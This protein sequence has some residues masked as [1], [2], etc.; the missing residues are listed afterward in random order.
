[1]RSFNLGHSQVLKYPLTEESVSK[2]GATR[3]VSP[4]P[5]NSHGYECPADSVF[6][7]EIEEV[8]QVVAL[9][10]AG[11]WPSE[12]MKKHTGQAA[13]SQL[14]VKYL[15]LSE[16]DP[17]R[18]IRWLAVDH[19]FDFW[20]DVV[21]RYAID[22]KIPM[23]HGGPGINFINRVRTRALAHE[24]IYGALNRTFDVKYQYGKCRP[25]EMFDNTVEVIDTPNHP[26]MPG[27][28]ATFFAASVGAFR[29]LYRPTPEQVSAVE[30]AGMQAGQGRTLCGIHFPTDNHVGWQIGKEFR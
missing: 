25:C 26:T 7:E 21:E 5:G 4:R 9:I 6:I 28:H 13:M 10:R 30:I 22:N 27:G 23:V 11:S 29:M 20:D 24:H 3:L 2:L 14:L 15:K 12:F 17:M 8:K 16:A 1:M 18:L 19:P